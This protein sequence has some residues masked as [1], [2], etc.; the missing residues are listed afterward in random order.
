MQRAQSIHMGRRGRLSVAAS[1]R[2]SKNFLSGMGELDLNDFNSSLGSPL[3]SYEEATLSLVGGKALQCWRLAKYG[4]PVRK[5]TACVVCCTLSCARIIYHKLISY[6]HIICSYYVSFIICSLSRIILISYLVNIEIQPIA[7]AFI[8]PTYVY[9]LHIE[10]AGVVE[11]IDEVFSSDLRV[12]SVR[13]DMKPKLATI[14]EKIMS[15]DVMEEVVE[16][17]ENFINTEKARSGGGSNI[18]YAVRSS[19]MCSYMHIIYE[20]M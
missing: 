19:G 20:S 4:F 1:A 8:L 15:T 9:S 12:E 2:G 14:R 11:L 18:S 5:L 10:A 6:A 7:S 13:H 3:E 16:N 17:V